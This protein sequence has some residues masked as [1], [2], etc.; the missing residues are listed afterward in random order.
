M[1]HGSYSRGD[2][3]AVSSP[4]PSNLPRSRTSLERRCRCRNR[5][6]RTVGH[7]REHHTYHLART[8]GTYRFRPRDMS[9]ASNTQPDIASWSSQVP[10]S[11]RRTNTESLPSLAHRHRGWST[12]ERT[13]DDCSQIQPNFPGSSTHRQRTRHC[14]STLYSCWGTRSNEFHKLVH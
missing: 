10:C 5:G 6:L 14:Q 7:T 13:R 8:R 1:C 4:D 11:P 9:R 2:T 3:G 12:T